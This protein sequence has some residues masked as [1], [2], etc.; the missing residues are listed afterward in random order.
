PDETG[1]VD[2]VALDDSLTRLGALDSRHARVVELRYLTGLNIQ[3]V[4]DVLGVSR[5]T[6]EMDWR[7]ARAWLQRDLG[8][9]LPE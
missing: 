5:R 4:A 2:L 9:E 3:E 8:F 7:L 1:D 6:V